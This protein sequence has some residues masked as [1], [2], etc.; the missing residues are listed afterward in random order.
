M[1]ANSEF[2]VMATQ[3][4]EEGADRRGHRG[5]KAAPSSSDKVN[6]KQSMVMMIMMDG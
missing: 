2:H 4:E 5:K 6:A 1:I 3:D